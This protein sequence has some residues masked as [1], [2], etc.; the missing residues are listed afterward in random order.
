M[1]DEIDISKINPG[2]IGL[3]AQL[4]KEL[5]QP[6]CPLGSSVYQLFERARDYRAN[7]GVDRRMRKAFY[8]GQMQ[9]QPEDCAQLGSINVFLGIF[10]RLRAIFLAWH[11]DR[12]MPAGEKQFTI[13]PTP[14]PD[15][16]DDL[17]AKAVEF[18]VDNLEKSGVPP[19]MATQYLRD[20]IATMKANVFNYMYKKAKTAT[21]K[22]KTSM[23]DTMVEGDYL[24][25]YFMWWMDFATY[26]VAIMQ[27]PCVVVKKRLKWKG[28][29]PKVIEDSV[30]TFRTISPLDFWVT[31]DGSN[32]NTCRAVFV[33]DRVTYETLLELSER[34]D[35]D[36]PIKRNIQAI[37]DKG[38]AGL[39]TWMTFGSSDDDDDDEKRMIE[40]R[41]YFV[42]EH[43]QGTFDVL[44]A[45]M[46]ISG[47]KAKEY[48]ITSVSKP[49]TKP[50]EDRRLY[51]VEMWMIDQMIVFINPNSH[52]LDDR[53]FYTASWE[54]IK[55]TIYG[56][57]LYDS[58]QNAERSACKTARDMIKSN[59]FSAGII[60]EVDG[61]RFA[62]GSVPQS[63]QPWKLYRTEV[64]VIGGAP[65][66]I[67]LQTIPSKAAELMAVHDHY[68][69]IAE[70]DTGIQ[71]FMSGALEGTSG[72]RTNGV[73]N[74]VQQNST[75]LINYR[76]MSAD[77]TCFLPMFKSL[78]VYHML[79][80]PDES[81][82]SDANIDLKGL[83]SVSTRDAQTQ[84]LVET[85]QYLPAIMQVMQQSGE[86]LDPKFIN[87]LVK[88]IFIAKGA[89]VTN[90]SDPEEQTAIQE[91]IGRNQNVEVQ[92]TL[93]G[94]SIP[95]P[96]ADEQNRLPA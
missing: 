83:T 89:D 31:S 29:K 23:L 43:A 32:P 65:S 56:K 16:P 66:A 91:A 57:S 58:V 30:M 22:M 26:P 6:N 88:S 38:E 84:G 12:V 17:R 9:Y 35:T 44:K 24:S 20:N 79:Y 71:D 19:E 1:A 67:Q 3:T 47:K 68:I 59:E 39:A 72:V 33:R 93:D 15:V 36:G 50:L 27:F 75:K 25:E 7:S 52:P 49:D 69:Q 18:V 41:S 77:R 37:L 10:A 63:L 48:G 82:K 61:S 8:S 73:A 28:S 40:G 54:A 95:P 94:R 86:T 55:G 92:P 70:K 13:E 11:F 96:T 85:L 81:I 4:E 78:W 46:K 2:S 64:P 60:A 5:E 53:G 34:A 42:T 51:E 21:E 80:N 62:D 76:A 14:V 90:L 45:Y 87:Q 74:T